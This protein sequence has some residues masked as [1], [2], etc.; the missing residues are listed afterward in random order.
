MQSLLALLT[1]LLCV[2][3]PVA[4]TGSNSAVPNQLDAI[5]TQNSVQQG[6]SLYEA[7]K[8]AAAVKAFQAAATTFKATGNRLGEAVAL[9]NISLAYQQLG[10]WSQAN[11]AITQSLKLLQPGRIDTSTEQ[12]QIFAQVLDIQG[13]LHLARGQAEAALSIWRQ[14]GDT[15]T[16]IGDLSGVTRSRINSAQALQNMGL[17]RQ[18]QKMLTETNQIL[19][20]ETDSALKA[21]GLRS[22]GH[23][24]RVV[25]DLKQSRQVL[26]QS[27][28]VAKRWSQLSV[29]PSPSTLR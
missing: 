2:V 24:L 13:R 28:E 14:A 9:S 1:A 26:Q 19:Q 10:Q 25:G 16:Q 8:F 6:T 21:T 15:Y 11:Q 17:Y 18:A 4:T 12:A 22:L 3:M 20:K 29:P 23:V 7:G 5:Q 27:L